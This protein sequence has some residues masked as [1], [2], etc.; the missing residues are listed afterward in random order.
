MRPFV[1]YFICSVLLAMLRIYC[2]WF[3][4]QLEELEQREV[5]DHDI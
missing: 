3:N 4:I 2:W 1:D 5:W